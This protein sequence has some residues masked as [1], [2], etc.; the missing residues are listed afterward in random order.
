VQ[1]TNAPVVEAILD[2]RVEWPQ[3]APTDI[4]QRLTAQFADTLPTAKKIHSVKMHASL[5]EEKDA[6]FR[7]TADV[8]GVRLDNAN[9]TRV[10]QFQKAG[11]TYSHMPPYTN[12]ET[13]S[14]EARPIWDAYREG[15]GVATVT[16]TAVR[17]INRF[18]LQVPLE[19]A[20][21]YVKLMPSVPPSLSGE[22]KHYAMQIARKLLIAPDSSVV[23]RCGANEVQK[24][25]TEFLLDFDVFI[26]APIDASS[27]VPWEWLSLLRDVKNKL[28]EDV[29]TDAAKVIFRG[30]NV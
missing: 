8:V 7:Q 25:V 21:E 26:N 17:F 11:F 30:S 19:R 24:D 5:H 13:F 20:P 22:T 23:I 16:R 14:G 2:F 15:A 4:F 3:S 29:V 9:N 12:W 1:Y 27:S 10:A 6:Q 18:Q 28:F